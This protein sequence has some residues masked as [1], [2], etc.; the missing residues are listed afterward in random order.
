MSPSSRTSLHGGFR[1]DPIVQQTAQLVGSFLD[2]GEHAPGFDELEV[3]QRDRRAERV[4]A[5][6]VAVVERALAEVFAEERSEHAIAATV[7]DIAR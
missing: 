3:P 6:G 1:R 7:T 2:V 4:P 5:V